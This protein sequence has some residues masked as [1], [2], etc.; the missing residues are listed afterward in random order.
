MS[1][2]VRIETV[3]EDGASGYQYLWEDLSGHYRPLWGCTVWDRSCKFLIEQG[4]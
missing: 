2:V 3:K 1:R 4:S